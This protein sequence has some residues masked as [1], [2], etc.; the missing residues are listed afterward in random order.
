MH[1]LLL[2][3]VLRRGSGRV[4][5]DDGDAVAGLNATTPK[6]K[7]KRGSWPTT[8]VR[9]ASTEEGRSARDRAMNRGGKELMRVLLSARRDARRTRRAFGGR[10]R[11]YRAREGKGACP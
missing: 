8:S 10:R 6:R 7:T 4:S 2:D 5:V 11:H 3:A 9:G 1:R